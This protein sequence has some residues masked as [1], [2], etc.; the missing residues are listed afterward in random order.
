[1]ELYD[2]K[3]RIREITYFDNKSSDKEKVE[4]YNKGELEETRI[5]KSFDTYNTVKAN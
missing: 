4:I 2:N 1:V 5:Y 3:R